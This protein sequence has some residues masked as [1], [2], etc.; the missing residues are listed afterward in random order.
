MHHVP[1]VTEVWLPHA[2]RSV[3]A[4]GKHAL[5]WLHKEILRRVGPPPSPAHT[6]G[7][8]MNGNSLDNRRS[9]LRWATVTENNRNKYGFI[10]KRWRPAA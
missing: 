7:D 5:I 10:V 1:A 9:N 6:V 3:N 4:G 8:H 2:A